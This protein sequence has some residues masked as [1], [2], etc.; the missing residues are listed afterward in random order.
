MYGLEDYYIHGSSHSTVTTSSE[1]KIPKM[2][3][4]VGILGHLAGHHSRDIQLALLTLFQVIRQYSLYQHFD[5]Y[6]SRDNTDFVINVSN[7]FY[8]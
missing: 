5:K 4:V 1:E 7:V 8:F 3:S 6:Q 2:A